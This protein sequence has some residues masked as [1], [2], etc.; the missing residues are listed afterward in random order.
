MTIEEILNNINQKYSEPDKD[1][2]IAMNELLFIKIIFNINI[3]YLLETTNDNNEIFTIENTINIFINKLDAD[4]FIKNQLHD[5][6]KVIIKEIKQSLLIKKIIELN[7]KTNQNI[8][9][10]IKKPINI[11]FSLKKAIKL[12]QL[13]QPQ[14]DKQVYTTQNNEINQKEYAISEARK[15]LDTLSKNERVRIK[16]NFSSLYKFS[17]FI[18]ELIKSSH[19]PHKKIE[20]DLSLQ[21]DW[22]NL[23]VKNNPSQTFNKDTIITLLKY[24][25]LEKYLYQF[26][27]SSLDLTSEL[28]N[29]NDLDNYYFE[30]SDYYDNTYLLNNIKRTEDVFGY[31]IYI[32]IFTKNN[33]ETLSCKFSFPINLIIGKKYSLLPINKE[34]TEQKT[35]INENIKKQFKKKQMMK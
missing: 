7:T 20:N 14:K 28:N 19:I 32:A 29:R 6:N 10:Y 31:Y 21:E 33:H 15:I 4:C 24:F 17:P 26:K 35:K 23:Y 25:N 18:Q 8:K 16:N 3:F 30:Q 27:S 2:K 11:N 9:L 13:K 5:N 12:L 34:N 22:I 1:K